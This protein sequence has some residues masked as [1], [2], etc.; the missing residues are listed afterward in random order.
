MIEDL[1][2]MASSATARVR[3]MVRRMVFDCR[4]E[5]TK[6]GSRR[7]PVLSQELSARALG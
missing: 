4:R 5:G 3:S 6:G 7:T 1:S 2:A